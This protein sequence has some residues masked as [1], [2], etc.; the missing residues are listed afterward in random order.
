[1]PEQD[2]SW[3]IG[4]LERASIETRKKVAKLLENPQEVKRYSWDEMELLIRRAEGFGATQSLR[5][6]FNEHYPK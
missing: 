3:V 1:M 4:E 2:Y 6:W 5:N